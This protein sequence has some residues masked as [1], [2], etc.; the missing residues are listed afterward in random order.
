MD[1]VRPRGGPIARGL[2][3]ALLLLPGCSAPKYSRFDSPFADFRCE[4]PWGWRAIVDSAGSDYVN[5]TFTGPLEPDFF[6]GVPSLGVRWYRRNAPHRLPDGSYEQYASAQ[7][8]MDQMLREVYGPD[9]RAWAGADKDV[10]EALSRSEKLPGSRR[11]GVSGRE[12]V[13]FVVFR[14]LPAP[15]GHAYGVVRDDL[16]NRAVLQR[17]AYALLPLNGG[18]YVLTYPATREGF[19]R[20]RPAFFHL[21]NT[22]VLLKDGPAGPG[23]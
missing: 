14:G 13:Y 1:P 23:A 7:D 2:A 18:F 11:I 4:V 20:Y 22:F 9:A 21:V 3:S 5:V 16:G 12:A 6:R 8:F 10:R 15:K 17:H 19:E